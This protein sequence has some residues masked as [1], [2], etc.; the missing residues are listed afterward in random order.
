M[1]ENTTYKQ[2]LKVNSETDFKVSGLI[3]FTIEPRCSLE[4]IGYKSGSISVIKLLGCQIT[5]F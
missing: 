5:K 4:K 3:Q 2:A 1:R